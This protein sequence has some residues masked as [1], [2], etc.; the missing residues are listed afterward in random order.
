MKSKQRQIEEITRS[1]YCSDILNFVGSLHYI[2]IIN[3]FL[4][5]LI[6]CKREM[7]A[8]IANM[9]YSDVFIFCQSVFNQISFYY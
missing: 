9:L 5:A 7:Y 4:V 3:R 2:Y 8:M 1:Q 6:K